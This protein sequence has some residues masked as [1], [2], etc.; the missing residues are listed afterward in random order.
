M[1]EDEERKQSPSQGKQAAAKDVAPA[2][3]FDRTFL[4]FPLE[5][6]DAADAG[7]SA[8]L[9]SSRSSSASVDY[10]S[11]SSDSDA[12]AVNSDE[13]KLCITDY[14]KDKQWARMHSP[15]R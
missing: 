6:S 8:L 13:N 14:K 4:T 3:A 2:K 7:T 11:S 5:G 1:E 10:G 15:E 12:S 9:P